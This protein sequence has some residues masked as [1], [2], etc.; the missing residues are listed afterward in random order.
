[1]KIR[2]TSR[3]STSQLKSP[4]HAMMI[5]LKNF[6]SVFKKKVKGFEKNIPRWYFWSTAND[7]RNVSFYH[8]PDLSANKNRFSEFCSSS[9]FAAVQ[10]LPIRRKD[11]YRFRSRW[12]WKGSNSESS[13]FHQ[14]K[15]IVL[16]ICSNQN[17]IDSFKKNTIFLYSTI[18]PNYF[19]KIKQKTKPGTRNKDSTAYFTLSLQALCFFMACS[20][21]IPLPIC[22]DWICR[23]AATTALSRQAQGFIARL[24]GKIKEYNSRICLTMEQTANIQFISVW[25][26]RA[27]RKN[28]KNELWHNYC[29]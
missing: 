16:I 1:M 12:K 2:G 14:L 17:E 27:Y 6:F 4:S 28:I 9:T 11:R 18:S 15:N 29:V 26:R 3:C 19:Q 22:R 20:K 23:K 10:L 8:F 25:Y 5:F 24:Y 7:I 21:Q 13:E